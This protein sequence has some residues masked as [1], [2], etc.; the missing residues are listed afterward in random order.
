V[1]AILKSPADALKVGKAL[2]LAQVADGAEGLVLADLARAIAAK[3]NSP[4]N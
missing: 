4:A 2:T 1:N 3:P